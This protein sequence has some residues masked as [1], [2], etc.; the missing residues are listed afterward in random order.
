M[1]PATFTRID[2]DTY[3]R[4]DHF[5]HYMTVSNCTYSMT[6]DID[7]TNL[8]QTAAERGYKIT[9]ALTYATAHAVN[10]CDAMRCALDADGNLGV[11]SHLEVSYPIF[12]NDDTTFTYL[13]TPME[14]EFAVYYENVRRDIALLGDKR[15]VN[16]TPPPEN[17]FSVSAIPWARFTGFNLNIL[18]DGKYLTPI[19]TWGQ[20]HPEYGRI[21]L[22]ISVQVHHA[23]TDGWHVSEFLNILQKFAEDAPSWMHE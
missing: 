23:A 2:M 3:P 7:I 14:A 20:F 11:W 17:S 22:P 5:E 9:P 21:L 12:H 15:G 16:A 1:K 6:V 4:K 8:H 19:I 10:S 18:T 13:T